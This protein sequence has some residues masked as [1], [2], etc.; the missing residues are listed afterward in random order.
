MYINYERIASLYLFTIV[1]GILSIFAGFESA[2]NSAIFLII[3]LLAV[4]AGALIDLIRF[5]SV[6]LAVLGQGNHDEVDD[7]NSPLGDRN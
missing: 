2:Q 1:F 3:F 7:S 6:S 5:L 4:I